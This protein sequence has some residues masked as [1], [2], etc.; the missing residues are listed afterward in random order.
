M[1]Y[2][3]IN[4]IIVM[5]AILIFGNCS[6]QS[7]FTLTSPAFLDGEFIPKDYSCEGKDLSPQLNWNNPTD[8]T[9]SYALICDDPDA[10]NGTWIHWVVFDIPASDTSILA[11]E[12]DLPIFENGMKQ[13]TTSFQRIGYGGPC[14]PSGKPH[15]YFFKLYALDFLTELKAGATKEDVL[16]I[17]D[18]HVLNQTELIGLYK[19]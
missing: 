10:P 13:G 4:K 9:V 8:G 1:K 19:R 7:S 12:E 15:R 16:K 6:A 18:G 2:S 14:P 5:V 17:I 3:L 11:G